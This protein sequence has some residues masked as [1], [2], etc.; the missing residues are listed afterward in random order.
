VRATRPPGL[1]DRLDVDD[2]I[3]AELAQPLDSLPS[4]IVER[5]LAGR[6]G[7][8]ASVLRASW[9]PVGSRSVV[10]T[11]PGYSRNAPWLGRRAAAV[12]V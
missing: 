11:A 5:G 2:A 4:R 8:Y 1:L 6:V 12:T 10:L 3:A 7:D 9:T